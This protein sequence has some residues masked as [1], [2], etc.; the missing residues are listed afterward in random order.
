MY[1]FDLRT[2]DSAYNFL[3]A[4]FNKSGQEYIEELIINSDNEFEKFWS[5][6]AARV[7][8]ICIDNIKVW[9][10]QKKR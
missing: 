8:D 9:G 10:F 6:N 3:L 7:N 2:S 1:N 5:R 4:F